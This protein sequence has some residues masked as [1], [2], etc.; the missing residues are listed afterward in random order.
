MLICSKITLMPSA[1]VV[2]GLLLAFGAGD[3]RADEMGGGGI[4]AQVARVASPEMRKIE[5]RLV[6]LAAELAELPQ[7]QEAPLASRYGFRSNTLLEQDAPHWVQ[8][9]LGRSWLIDRIAAVPAHIPS[10]GNRGD[11]YGF[12]LRFKIEVA[13]DP[14]MEEAVT[15][16]DRT[17]EDVANPGRY[18]MTFRLE[19]VQGR[20]LRFTSTRHFPVE[21]GFIWAL[22]ELVI[23]SGN[24][25][26]GVNG[27]QT[28][29]S[30]L[31]LYP[32]WSR[33]RINDGQSALGM[34]S[35]S[36]E[37]PTRGYLSAMT[38]DS[39]D[40]KWLQVDL[41]REFALDEIRLLPVE[42]GNFETLGVLSFPRAWTLE[43]ANDPEFR[44]V[45]WRHHRE[46][47]TLVG[48]PGGCGV[49]VSGLAHRGRYLRLSTQELWGREDQA[50]FGLAEVQAYS[51]GENVALG[52]AVQASDVTDKPDA[53]GWAP[54]FVV[55]G[56]T[57]RH[58]LIEYPEYLDLIEER[59]Q[60]DMEQNL[61]LARRDR[62]VRVT[63]LVLGYGG[64]TLGAVAVLGWGWMLV[65]QRVVKRRA[66]V[67]LR[68]QI[69][70]DLH[71]DIGCN[72]GGIVLLSDMGSKS[73]GDGQAREDF[74]T[75]RET[76]EETSQSMKDIV[77]LIQH[78]D[79]RLRDL[80][81]RMRRATEIVLGD[82]SVSLSVEPAEYRNR[83]VSLLFRRHVF[84]AFKEALNNVR[85][86]SGATL[87]EVNITIS[88]RDLNFEV[89][90]DG[91]GFDPQEIE[92]RGNGLK[93]LKLRAER[94]K[95]T[96]RVDST[97]GEGTCISF[98]SPLNADLK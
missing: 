63:G 91:R 25:T 46:P 50:G 75:I 29:S 71:D 74:E 98:T 90:D 6:E 38:N 81:T 84:F 65:R 10:L 96:C 39:K 59:G 11:G 80:V 22:E 70:R 55:D 34:P 23:L 86:H 44:E 53:S 51:G 56:F 33:Q 28:A 24:N 31:E 61:L 66:V 62:K 79:T 15:V 83:K 48:H 9:D 47:A 88:D 67:Q 5:T 37:S 12:P 76:A 17:A 69:A 35:T 4:A 30:S 13:N 78:G 87:V 60:L 93:N 8:I 58:R 89:R 14:N 82:E 57:S 18:P 7:L 54:E 95:G 73:S 43:L 72:L 42:S 32:N 16:V 94:L 49:V 92:T 20:Y 77:W 26:L 45:T 85:K 36:E 19:P 27:A 40:E 52:K 1:G 68:E 64:G 21:E 97:P 3:L 2:A 41:E